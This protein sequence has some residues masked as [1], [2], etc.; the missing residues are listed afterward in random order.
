MAVGD[1]SLTVTKSGS[2]TNPHPDFV[3]FSDPASQAMRG[4]RFGPLSL[5]SGKLLD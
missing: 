3:A 2:Y 5:L 4:G 1:G